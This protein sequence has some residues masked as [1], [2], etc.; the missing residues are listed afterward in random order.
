MSWGK[1]QTD[2]DVNRLLARYATDEQKRLQGFK[3]AKLYN[4]AK[5]YEKAKIY[6]LGYLKEKPKEPQALEFMGEIEESLGNKSEALE[7]Y[8]KAYDSGGSKFSKLILK[9]SKLACDIGADVE[10]LKYWL[11]KCRPL[12]PQSLAVVR[13]R[14]CISQI[15][16][17]K[18]A[19]IKSGS[20][21]DD[22]LSLLQYI[23]EC[24]GNENLSTA[25][26]TIII[27]NYELQFVNK[28]EWFNYT[29]SIFEAAVE[30]N[31]YNTAASACLLAS[32]KISPVDFGD[33]M[34]NISWRHG[35]FFSW[36]N[37]QSQD[38]FSQIGH[39]INTL[40]GGDFF[41]W[42]QETKNAL[43]SADNKHYMFTLIF[44]NVE[45]DGRREQTLFFHA[46]EMNCSR[47]QLMPLTGEQLTAYDTAAF[48]LHL[49]N[50]SHL[51]WLC[52]Q[53]YKPEMSVQPVYPFFVIE[54]LEH[55]FGAI[56]NGVPNSLCQTDILVFLL[57]TVYCVARLSRHDGSM[58]DT[59]L[60]PPSA[61]NPL[62]SDEQAN[63]WCAAYEFL[64]RSDRTDD[65]HVRKILVRGIETVRL[66]GQHGMSVSLMVHI[67]RTLNKKLKYL[68]DLENEGKFSLKELAATEKRTKLFWKNIVKTLEKLISHEQVEQTEARLF[69]DLPETDLSLD[70]MLMY[71]DEAHF[72]LAVIAFDNSDYSTAVDGFQFVES[73]EAKLF[74]AKAYKKWAEKEK[75]E[76]GTEYEENQMK[77]E[78][79]TLKAREILFDMVD[80]YKDNKEFIPI[81]VKELNEV[82]LLIHEDR[83]DHSSGAGYYERHRKDSP[84]S[85]YFPDLETSLNYPSKSSARKNIFPSATAAAAAYPVWSDVS[86]HRRISD[87]DPVR[88]LPG[89]DADRHYDLS[90]LTYS[91]ADSLIAQMRD[92]DH[93]HHQ[94]L[95]EVSQKNRQI[96]QNQELIVRLVTERNDQMVAINSQIIGE[97]R[98]SRQAWAEVLTQNTE[99]VKDVKN[100][101][102]ESRTSLQDMKE[103]IKNLRY[104]K[105]E[106][107]LAATRNVNSN[108]SSTDGDETRNH[109]AQS[110]S[111]K[112]FE[113]LMNTPRSDLRSTTMMNQ[114]DRYNQNHSHERDQERNQRSGFS[115]DYHLQSGQ[116][117]LPVNSEELPQ[118]PLL[119]SSHEQARI[120]SQ[121]QIFHNVSNHQ[122]FFPHGTN[123]PPVIPYG[124]NQQPVL[125]YGTNQQPVLSYGTNL[126][127]VF[128]YG[129]NQQP[130]F[131]C[132]TNQQPS[133]FSPGKSQQIVNFPGQTQQIVNYQELSQQPIVVCEQNQQPVNSN[134]LKQQPVFLN[135]IKQQPAM[136]HEQNQQPVIS[137]GFNQQPVA[138]NET[139]QQPFFLHETNQ[140][141][142]FSPGQTQQIVNSQELSQ[143]PLVVHEQNQQPVI[144]NG[145]NQ[146]PVAANERNQQPV[147]LHERNQQTFASDKRNQQPVLSTQPKQQPAVSHERNQPTGSQKD[148][149]QPMD[150]DSGYW[151]SVPDFDYQPEISLPPL[152]EKCTG[153]EDETQIFIGKCRLYRFDRD[154]DEWTERGVGHLKILRHNEHVKFRIVMRRE[155]VS[156]KTICITCS[157]LA[158]CITIVPLDLANC[159]MSMVPLDLANCIMS[160]ITL[161]LA[162]CIISMVPLDLAHCIMSMVPLDL[163]NCIMSMVPLDLA[164]CIMSMVPLDLA[165][166]ILSMVPLDLAHC[167]MSMVPLDLAHC[168][169]SMVP[170]D[171]AHCIMS[172][173]P[174][175]LAHCIMSMVP[176][177]L[178]HCIMSMVPKDLAHCIMSMVPLDLAHCILSMVPLD[179]AHCILSMVPLDLANCIM[180]M[181]PLDLA[182]C[183]M[184]MVPLDLA[185]CILSMVPLDLAHCIMSMVPLDLAH[186]IMSM[187]PLDLANCI[188]SMVPLDLAHCIMSMVPLD[189]A[190]CIMSMVP[191][192]LAN[193][194]MSMVPLDLAHCIMSMVPLDLAHCIMS[195]VPLDLAH[196]I[197]S[198]VPLDLAHCPWYHWKLKP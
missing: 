144:S 164:H 107:N 21:K 174:L 64:T 63:W 138:A 139:N 109:S 45:D 71:R 12:Y 17:V 131:P 176:M 124:S 118:Q 31:C 161:D 134:E 165:H 93:S 46:P 119:I 37:L 122:P 141:S 100:C 112:E 35:K 77:F 168:I 33:L 56:E 123:Q 143:Q 160:M 39:L 78:R 162:H 52:L 159:I 152:A 113:Q 3:V 50:L 148:K 184:S 38:R 127:P 135:K 84:G 61:I 2:R 19:G 115:Q 167:I 198:M 60:L 188:M 20:V 169:M 101:L 172:M 29:C 59:Q 81:I 179:L 9:I 102:E 62:C 72:S 98:E 95:R 80:V 86:F 196:C 150:T 130:V 1:S 47:S 171:L 13:L 16:K 53:Y 6:L 83:L 18:E 191:L 194:I 43:V 8:K 114:D 73:P 190:H 57:A 41:K 120:L 26:E 96:S 110:V 34:T 137:N 48:K 146:Q 185:H 89:A 166:C 182:N 106:D 173:V 27:S 187:V 151:A 40:S 192:D 75:L 111:G 189:L 51:V 195:M 153:E 186:C 70:K 156:Q 99:M 58:D 181:V 103:E 197:M 25:Y 91:P 87:T 36:W 10:T 154:D 193:C 14:V 105:R 30:K 66:V 125:S 24:V 7:Y 155:K 49:N 4:A 88:H 158:H 28:Q 5:D 117:Q 55:D 44:G 116:N 177:D 136:F 90:V 145:F 163:A 126:Q 65:L 94:L 178:A 32:Y 68:M 22:L 149:N 128:P 132:G 85:D 108:V 175:D 76:G 82:D 79:L 121:S 129:S 133:V 183:I 42:S 67:A 142:V 170:L 104:Q 157:I 97:L 180:S 92:L 147:F 54:K 69:I 74:L 23:D 140:Q 15:N 11:E